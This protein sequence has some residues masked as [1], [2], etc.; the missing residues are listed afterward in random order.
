MN[1][2]LR[3][4]GKIPFV[5][6][7]YCMELF[8]QIQLNYYDWYQGTAKQQ[9]EILRERGIPVMVMEPVHGGMLADMPED[10]LP[11]LPGK[12]ASPAAWALRFVMNLP[13][14]AVVLSGMSDLQQTE[15]NVKTASQ[16]DRMT[17][18][19]MAELLK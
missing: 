11:Y 16:K 1:D 4:E 12:D 7:N 6:E 8:A 19:E 14:V 13:G 15:E 10:C 9:Y 2:I 17:A 3:R 5:I 18:E